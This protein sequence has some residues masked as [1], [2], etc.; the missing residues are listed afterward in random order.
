MGKADVW[1]VLGKGS[2]VPG[3]SI[4]AA[5]QTENQNNGSADHLELG[6]RKQI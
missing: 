5:S 3:T 6:Y 4:N 2:T 1:W